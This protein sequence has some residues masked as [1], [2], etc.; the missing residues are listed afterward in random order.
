MSALHE[1]LGAL[2]AGGTDCHIIVGRYDEAPTRIHKDTAGVFTFVVQGTKRFYLWPFER[3]SELAGPNAMYGQINLRHLNYHE[4]LDDAILLEGKAG[5]AFYWPAS[6]WHCGESDGASHVTLHVANYLY[7]D[8]IASAG[9]LLMKV[10]DAESGE[11]Q[12]IGEVPLP[13][14]RSS[15]SALPVPFSAALDRFTD[16]ALHDHVRGLLRATWLRRVTGGNF[17]VVP[18]PATVSP[19]RP[20]DS[21]ARMRCGQW[22][23]VRGSPSIAELGIN[24]Q[25]SRL[26]WRPWLTSLLDTLTTGDSHSVEGLMTMLRLQ[27]HDLV[28]DELLSVIQELVRCRALSV[29]AAAED[30]RA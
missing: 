24:G 29:R 21:V 13:E 1:V 19:V 22:M 16:P 4:Y 8:P 15:A 5:D 18:P 14:L 25:V 2:P 28:S 20:A 26:P 11:D 30:R 23:V 6:Y 9:R 12:W 27:G 17:E 10:L 3:F 7:R